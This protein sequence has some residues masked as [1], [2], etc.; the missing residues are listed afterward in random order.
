M[1][2]SKVINDNW[3]PIAVDLYCGCGGLTTGLKQAGFKV[4]AAVDNDPL[5]IL[6]YYENHPEVKL[7]AEDIR[8]IKADKFM[9]ELGLEPGKL[10]LLAGC[11]PC[12]GFSS[13]RTL[14]GALNIDDPR[15]DLLLE[16]LRFVELLMPKAVMFENVPGL[17]KDEIFFYFC[18]RMKQLGY[19]DK[20]DILDAANYGVPQRRRRLIYIAG[21]GF[22]IPF[23][24]VA[25]ERVTYAKQ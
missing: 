18:E 7:Y 10:D 9:E 25:A 14:N 11:P 8:D 16:F 22:K 5:S 21:Y 19:L 17:S 12:Q 6:T 20:Y 4:I 3:N 24:N 13:V 2:E 15:N 1:T 23:A